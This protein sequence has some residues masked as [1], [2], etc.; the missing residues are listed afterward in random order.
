M[1][2]EENF[3]KYFSCANESIHNLLWMGMTVDAKEEMIH[4]YPKAVH[5]DLTSRVQII[6]KSNDFFYSLLL[7][8]EQKDIDMLINTSF[9]I[10]GDPMVFDFVDC[11]TNMKRMNIQYLITNNGLYK[12]NS[13]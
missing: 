6:N 13:I 7:K 11:Y 9:N 4:R 3:H 1:I 10:A 5:I 2:R 8:L 12:I